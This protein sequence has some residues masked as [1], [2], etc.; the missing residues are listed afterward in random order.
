MP[1]ASLARY[2]AELKAIWAGVWAFVVLMV[3]HVVYRKLA[4]T[5][6]S[7]LNTHT[8]VLSDAFVP[9]TKPVLFLFYIS[10]RCSIL[11]VSICGAV[12]IKG[13]G[14]YS[15]SSL[16]DEYKSTDGEYLYPST[17]EDNT[18]QYSIHEKDAYMVDIKDLS[19]TYTPSLY[20]YEADGTLVTG[21]PGLFH[22]TNP[23]I[24]ERE[25]NRDGTS[26]P[27]FLP[28]QEVPRTCQPRN[29][30]C[31][32]S[33]LYLTAN[34]SATLFFFSTLFTVTTDHQ[35]EN[36]CHSVLEKKSCSFCSLW[37]LCSSVSKATGSG[38]NAEP[39][40][41][42]PSPSGMKS[43]LIKSLKTAS[44]SNESESKHYV[45]PVRS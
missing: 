43:S 38:R 8:H 7:C 9:A 20:V 4:L 41:T 24:K 23:R 34:W 19:G 45:C 30:L 2:Q 42:Q 44:S 40:A 27:K 31:L 18:F 12:Y 13:F 36:L 37:S 26:L 1:T 28:Q 21:F 22:L 14:I 3:L 33:F 5:S 10:D 29:L 11:S 35:V 17:R 32:V 25:K 39:V 6:Y 16:Q 15:M